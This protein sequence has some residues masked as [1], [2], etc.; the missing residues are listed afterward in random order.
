MDDEGVPPSGRSITL[1]DVTNTSSVEEQ[2]WAL[3]CMGQDDR[4]KIT[5]L[6]SSMR[7]SCRLDWGK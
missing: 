4:E 1:T 5:S 2:E 7:I 6:F 3:T